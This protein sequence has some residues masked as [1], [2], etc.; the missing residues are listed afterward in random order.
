MLP[1]TRQ[2][3]FTVFADYNRAIWPA[4]I[5]AY[6]LALTVIAVALRRPR[7][8]DR[9]APALLTL[10]WGWTGIAY[11]ARFFFA[12][13]PAALGFAALFVLQPLLFAQV[14]LID[15]LR[16]P[17]RRGPRTLWGWLLVAY[18]SVAYPLLGMSTGHGWPA[19]PMF[20]VAPCPVTLFTFGVLLLA[21]QPV[22]R[23]LLV[24]PFLWGLIG[25]SAA[26]LLAVPQDW[27]L[28]IG[29][30]LV[31]PWLWRRAPAFPVTAS[32]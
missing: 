8:A 17:T 30:A 29:T 3:F 32:T 13:N 28:L 18:A 7:Y 21:Q 14:A 23:R 27:P 26:L 16:F 10:M 22:P 20:G 4:Q 19:M 25:G 5:L 31:V 11:H 24:I 2:Q 6:V 1:F 12:I 15:G 9:A